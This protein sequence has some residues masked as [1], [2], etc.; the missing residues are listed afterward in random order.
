M[1]CRAAL[2]MSRTL[3]KANSVATEGC[4]ELPTLAGT[5]WLPGVRPG[6]VFILFLL[7][8]VVALELFLEGGLEPG[9]FVQESPV[10]F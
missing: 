5:K 6:Y 2:A 7:A 8:V 3:C 9:Q 10:S 4:V 1:D